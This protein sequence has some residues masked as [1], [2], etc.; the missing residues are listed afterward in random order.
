MNLKNIK[1]INK[2]SEIEDHYNFFLI[3]LWGVI[4]N[5]IKLFPTVVNVLENLKLKDK[6]VFFYHQRPAK[7]S[8]N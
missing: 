2:I 5:G 4:H 8:Y 6:N 3:D 1:E 7:S